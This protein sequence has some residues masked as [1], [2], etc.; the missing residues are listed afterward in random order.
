MNSTMHEPTY[1]DLSG[2]V[3]KPVESVF[4]FCKV[5]PVPPSPKSLF[6]FTSFFAFF[7][8]V[9]LVSFHIQSS[10]CLLLSFL[11]YYLPSLHFI[12]LS[13][14]ALMTAVISLYVHIKYLDHVFLHHKVSYDFLSFWD[15]D[16]KG[17]FHLWWLAC[18][19]FDVI[20]LDCK[21]LLPNCVMSFSI[22]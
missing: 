22:F 12:L 7:F 1:M 9:F 21:L 8:T 6:P 18:F 15:I 10:S 19:L 14:A 16:V 11:S 2:Q 17:S 20:L 5:F 4:F 3:K 13:F